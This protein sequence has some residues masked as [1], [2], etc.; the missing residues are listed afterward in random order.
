MDL[1]SELEALGADV[2]DAL[3]RFSGNA[4]LYKRML[5][6]FPAS[7]EGLEVMSFLKDGDYATAVSNAH[8]LKGVTGNLSLSPLFTAYTEIV[9]SLRANEPEKALQTLENTLPV[10][11]KIIDCIKSGAAQ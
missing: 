2:P 1:L 9:N 4:D 11:Q 6:K 7:A 10:Q 5:G 8:T 3:K